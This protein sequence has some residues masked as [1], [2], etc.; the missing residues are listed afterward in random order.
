MNNNKNTEAYTAYKK[1]FIGRMIIMC[2][3]FAILT[4][5]LGFGISKQSDVADDKQAE[6]EKMNKEIKKLEEAK[7]ELN[8]E[9]TRLNDEAYIVELAREKYYFSK[10]GEIIFVE[11]SEE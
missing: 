9:I 6:V 2:A 8:Y 5:G 3:G 11:K 7:K 10:D 1:K 4:V